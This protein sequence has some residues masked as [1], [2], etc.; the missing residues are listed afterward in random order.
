MNVDF[1]ESTAD[2]RRVNKQMRRRVVKLKNEKSA[3]QI[4]FTGGIFKARFEGGSDVAFGEDPQQATQR[5]HKLPNMVR[6][7][8][9]KDCDRAADRAERRGHE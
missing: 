8:G 6:G 3:A 9:A 4:T 2:F 5:L 7:R 1:L